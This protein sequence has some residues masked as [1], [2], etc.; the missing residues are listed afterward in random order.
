[1]TSLELPA[2]QSVQVTI[3]YQQSKMV[4]AS[5][6][7]PFV[8]HFLRKTK[9]SQSI[10]TWMNY[11]HDLKVFF[12][13]LNL[14]LEQIDR[15]ACLT[16]MEAQNHAG[17]SSLTINRRLAAVSSLFAELNL[18]NPARFP[19]NPV[20]PLQRDRTTRTRTQSLYRRQPDRVPDVIAEEDLQAFFAVLPIFSRPYLDSAHV[21]QLSAH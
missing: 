2:D 15:Q 16:F 13:T 1:M 14:P 12:R 8:D 18:L 19:Q 21:D 17:L 5:T 4:A 6:N 10:H 9:L 11:A 20:I 7:S 3:E